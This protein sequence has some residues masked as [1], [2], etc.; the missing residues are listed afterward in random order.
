MTDTTAVKGTTEPVP[1][2]TE[3]DSAEGDVHDLIA[4]AQKAS[5]FLKILSHEGR[6]MILCHL[7]DAE[8][9]VAELEELLNVR[10]ST[11]SQMLARL[12][13]EGLVT[14]RRDGKTIYYSLADNRA[15]RLLEA[16]H[17]MFCS[18]EPPKG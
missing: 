8:R 6:L 14:T 16:V 1:V 3:V 13:S 2:P 11:V 7:V 18:I 5:D 10:Q 15:R 4:N 17:E 9:S 12:R